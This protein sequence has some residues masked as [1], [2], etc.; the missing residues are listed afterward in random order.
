MGF[1]S[2]LKDDL[3]QAVNELMP[4]EGAEEE[5]QETVQSEA[6][7]SESKDDFNMDLSEMLDQMDVGLPAQEVEKDPIYAAPVSN[8][9]IKAPSSK[10]LSDE[11]SVLTESMIINGNI[12]TEGS[13]DVRGSIVGNVEALGKLNVT[14]AI[15]GNSQAAEVYAEN[16]KITGD[17]RSE[18]SI[19]VG[20]S[21]V[22]IGNVFATSAVIAG[23][24]KGDIDVRGPVI[25]DAS[26]IVMG[27]IKSKSVQINNGAVIE[28]MCS[29]CY[30]EV[31]PTS[32]F[33]ELK[34]M[35]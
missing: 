3:S 5:K 25:L 16:A 24:I 31:N 30:A 15:Q 10:K 20:Q 1:F 12:A 6:P 26:A 9:E 21:T 19:K 34:K 33:D 8:V 28:G 35:K 13:L 7:I 17:L 14:G 23:A 22:I 11:V 2:D 4:E 27:N 18:G 32:F 29:Q